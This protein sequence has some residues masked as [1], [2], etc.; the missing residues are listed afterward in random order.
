[1]I[2][3]FKDNELKQLFKEGKG[4]KRF[5]KDLIKP[6][7]KKLA[8]LEAMKVLTDL[9]IP[10]SNRFE[11]LR[12]DRKG[13]YSISVNMKYRLCFRFQDG[14]VYDLEWTNHYR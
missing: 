9:Y 2:K 5:S 7:F 12:G 1:M 13:Q 8:M 4:N 6:I 3:T 14:N 11:A 10:P